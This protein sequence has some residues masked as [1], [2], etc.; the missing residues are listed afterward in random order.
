MERPAALRRLPR[1]FGARLALIAGAALALRLLQAILVAPDT[2]PLTD[3]D[4]FRQVGRFLSEGRGFIH[5]G[6]L[7]FGR[8]EPTA[9][10]PP[11][12]PLLLAGLN[13]LGI[14][15]DEAQRCLNCFIGT[16]TVVLLGLLGRRVARGGVRPLESGMLM[17]SDP[18]GERTGLLA[19]GIGALYPT[20]V[21]AD[22]TALSETLFGLL[23]AAAMLSGYALLVRPTVRAALVLGAAV[24]LATLTRAEG[25][26]LLP[27]LALPVAWRAAPSGRA[28]RSLLAAAAF[29]VVLVPWTVRN[30]IVFDQ[31]V[32]VS[33]NNATVIAGANCDRTYNR[34]DIGAFI[35]TCIDTPRRG[36]EAEHAARLRD[37]GLDYAREHSGRVPVVVAVRVLR[38]WGLY[39]PRRIASDGEGRLRRVQL[40]GVAVYYPLLGLAVYA[41]ALLRRRRDDLIVLLAPVAMA[42]ITG[43]LAY[44]GL[45]LRHAAEVPLV[46]LAGVGLSALIERRSATPRR[47]A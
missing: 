12:W 30:W 31:P 13:E 11:L 21:A 10:H 2:Q 3:G 7:L 32:P 36:N 14:T 47:S 19:A 46:V 39:Q 41:V 18:S 23:T 45:R 16:G 35:F 27:F 6:E 8:E 43:A 1:G 20:L 17:G 9:E 40:A 22:G 37:E 44:G 28:S 4:Y 26:L 42:T 38:M 25:L 15:S 5:P 33:N 34:G 29:L 24:G